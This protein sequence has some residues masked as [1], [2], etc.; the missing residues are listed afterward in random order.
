MKNQDHLPVFGVGPFYGIVV[1]ATTAATVY[2]LVRGS[3]LS[4]AVSSSGL[5]ILMFVA[6]LALL[7]LGGVVWARAALGKGCIDKYILRNELCTE[8]VYRLVRNPCY[9]GIMFACTG[10]LCLFSNLIVIPLF[11]LY[12]LAMTV[13]MKYTEE[14]WLLKQYGQAYAEYCQSVNRCIPWI[15]K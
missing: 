13:L 12:W 4:L 8:G 1:I 2:G 6:G 7:V 14:K 9:S 10:V 3:F 5:R 15:K 11:L